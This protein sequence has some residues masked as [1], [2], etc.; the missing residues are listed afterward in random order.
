VSRLRGAGLEPLVDAAKQ[1]MRLAGMSEE[2]VARVVAQG[3]VQPRTVIVSPISGI[4]TELGV[5]EGTTVAMGAPLF[6]INGLGSVWIY[7][8]LP[9]SAAA[10]VRAGAAV[11]VRTA[12]SPET[13][14][15]G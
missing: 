11:E 15:K 8:E 12:A 1:R 5:R 14:F 6:R 3:S 9:E 13:V 2:Q 7:A 10:R 4:V